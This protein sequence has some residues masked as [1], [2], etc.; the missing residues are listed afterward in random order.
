MM[1]KQL[2]QGDDAYLK[3][4]KYINSITYIIYNTFFL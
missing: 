4:K 2:M 3:F 1:H